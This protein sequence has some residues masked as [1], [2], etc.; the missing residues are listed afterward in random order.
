MLEH[1]K[2]RREEPA[3]RYDEILSAAITLAEK[4]GFMEITRE[5]VA[6]EADASC[7]LITRYFK[8]MDNL[9]KRV[10]KTAI[11]FERLPIIAQGL[12][13]GKI[14]ATELDK[15]LLSKVLDFLKQ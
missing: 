5:S 2:R 12:S 9:K 14:Q 3:L 7:A 1:R 11:E 8:T 15:K 13:L 6:L 4:I 10:L